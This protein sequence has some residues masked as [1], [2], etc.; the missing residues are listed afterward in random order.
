M[1]WKN[2]CLYSYDVMFFFWM[3]WKK[4]F[5][6]VVIVTKNK[7]ALVEKRIDLDVT[8][9]PTGGAENIS[10]NNAR[11]EIN[12]E[13]SINIPEGAFNV[14]VRVEEATVWNTVA[15]ISSGLNNHHIFIVDDGATIDVTI[16]NGSYS[17]SSLSSAIDRE[18]V[19]LGGTSGLITLAEDFATQRVIVNVNGSLATAPGAQ[20]DWSVARTN[21]FRDVVG[22]DAQFVPALVTV[23]D[24]AQ[25]GDDVAAFNNIEYFLIHWDGGQGIRTNNSYTSV[26]TRVNITVPPGSQIVSTP[27]NPGESEASR[28]GGTSRNHLVFWLTNQNNVEVDTGEVWSARMAF[29]WNQIAE[30]PR[31]KTE[32]RKRVRPEDGSLREF[33]F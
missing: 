10:A 31:F 3:G 23:V 32:T 28:W 7:M 2:T 9:S 21:T 19:A 5:F 20:I 16:P 12:L 24:T 11:F 22:F 13:Q 26:L 29:V 4:N 6:C 18:Y 14:R 33:D 17:T 25:L 15:N 8:S 30:I 27:F 1:Y